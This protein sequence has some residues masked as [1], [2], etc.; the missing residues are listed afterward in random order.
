VKDGRERLPLLGDAEVK[1]GPA[2]QGL[3][4]VGE[5]IRVGGHAVQPSHF[6]DVAAVSS[7]GCCRPD[8]CPFDSCA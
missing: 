6:G 5:E 1:Y 4:L 3:G 2:Q 8:P 7:T